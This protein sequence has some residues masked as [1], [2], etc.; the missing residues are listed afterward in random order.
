MLAEHRKKKMRHGKDPANS[1]KS[2]QLNAI[3]AYS[4]NTMGK[5]GDKG[6]CK[7]IDVKD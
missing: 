2:E 3:K 1:R 6:R 5:E 4:L 7:G